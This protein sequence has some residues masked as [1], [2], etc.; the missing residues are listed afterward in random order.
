MSARTAVEKTVVVVGVIV[1]VVG[2]ITL[3][4]QVSRDAARE[5]EFADAN[6]QR[7]LVTASEFLRQLEAVPAIVHVDDR[8]L[9]VTLDTARAR[10][11]VLMCVG[12]LCGIPAEWD[13][14]QREL[15]ALHRGGGMR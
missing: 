10:R 12:T 5:Q 4:L 6:V 3:T 14:W 9:T 7:A 11:D 1:V 8:N 15:E 2:A 13:R